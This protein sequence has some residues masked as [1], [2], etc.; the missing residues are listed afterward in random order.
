MFGGQTPKNV[1]GIRKIAL[2]TFIVYHVRSKA[3]WTT[4]RCLFWVKFMF[5]VDKLLKVIITLEM[6]GYDI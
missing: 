3:V 6:S 1:I 4:Y 5:K 2:K